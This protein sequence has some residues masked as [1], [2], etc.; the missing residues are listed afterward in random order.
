MPSLLSC[1][2]PQARAELLRLFFT[3]TR[4]RLHMRDATR[5]SGLT[6]ATVQAELKKLTSCGLLHQERD[7]NRLYFCANSEHPVF[8]ELCSLVEK[9]AGIVPALRSALEGAAGV[10]IAFIFGSVAAQTEKPAS[11]VDVMLIGSATLRSLAP[12]MRRVSE[13]LHREINP[14][15]MTVAEWQRRL[16]AQD[17]FIM[18]VAQEPKLW[19]KGDN[20]ELG[21]LG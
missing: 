12:G 19:L 11:D 9:T 18:R 3:G 2:F 15:I 17:A 21:Q 1:L 4:A 20:D 10:E 13:H 8:P 6:L 7:G 14:H 5:Q 16:A